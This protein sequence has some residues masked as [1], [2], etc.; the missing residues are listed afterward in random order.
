VAHDILD[1]VYGALI[2]GAIGDA[3]GALATYT[4]ARRTRF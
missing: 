2:A 1:A 4:I 3:L